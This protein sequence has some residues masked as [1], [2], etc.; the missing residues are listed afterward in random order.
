V[1]AYKLAYRAT[2]NLRDLNRDV[3]SIKSF[4]LCIQLR[5]FE[6]KFRD[7]DYLSP[8]SLLYLTDAK[9]NFIKLCAV[10]KQSI[11]CTFSK[12]SGAQIQN[13]NKV[14]YGAT[15]LHSARRL[16]DYSYLSE[17]NIVLII[18]TYNKLAFMCRIVIIIII[19]II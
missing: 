7:G 2:A 4:L 9:I 17:S 5:H 16:F 8:H 14:M 18:P 1:L 19:I 13:T 6:K 3:C 10:S 12:L 15:E 11:G